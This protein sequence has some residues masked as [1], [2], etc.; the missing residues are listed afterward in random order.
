MIRLIIKLA[1]MF[2]AIAGLFFASNARNVVADSTSQQK[3]AAPNSETALVDGASEIIATA[4]YTTTYSLT[5]DATWSNQTHPHPSFPPNAHFSPLIGAVH[6][7][8]VTFW[9]ADGVSVATPGIEQM[10]E[11]G[12]TSLLSDEIQA[13]IPGNA[14]SMLTR[15]GSFFSPSTVTIDSFEVSK[16]FPLVTLVTMVAPS[17]DWFV[18]VSSLSLLDDG[19]RWVISKTVELYPYDAGTDSGVDYTS[20]DADVTPHVPITNISGQFPFSDQPLGTLTFTRLETDET[21]YLPLIL[22]NKGE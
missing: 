12:G 1:P 8:T 5:F 14:R 3:Y 17:P 11:T 10:A 18:G 19:G 22:I 15:P 13:Q 20:P 21:L 6:T 2:A 9:R 4:S 7:D 16:D